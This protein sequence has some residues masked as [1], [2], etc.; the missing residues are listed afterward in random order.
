MAKLVAKVRFDDGSKKVGGKSKD[1]EI[2]EEYAGDKK[3]EAGLKKQGLLCPQE[4]L[5]VAKDVLKDKDALI[6][7]LQDENRN[8]K[9]A[10]EAAEAKIHELSPEKPA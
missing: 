8:L 6:A 5:Q 1:Y 4:E 2:G 7:S 10:V 3:N 9:L